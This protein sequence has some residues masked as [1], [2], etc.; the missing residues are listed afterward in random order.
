[1]AKRLP[2]PYSFEHNNGRFEN[3]LSIVIM[4]EY[5]GLVTSTNSEERAQKHIDRVNKK[6]PFGVPLYSWVIGVSL[7]QERQREKE[8]RQRIKKHYN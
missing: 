1:M 6:Y 5:T 4:S 8:I 2:K 3:E 7:E